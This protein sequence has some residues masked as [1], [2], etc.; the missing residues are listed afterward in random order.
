M[1][2]VREVMTR[3]KLVTVSPSA[4]VKEAAMRMYEAGVGSVLIVDEEMRLLGIFT[5]RDLVRIVATETPLD[6]PVS[7][8]MTTRLVTASPDESL[9]M[10]ASKMIEHGIRHI[11]VVDESGRLI[12]IV[13]IRDVLRHIVASG[14][15]P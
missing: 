15:W 1:S 6:T 7:R 11:P 13:S 9:A 12:G 2:S 3:D 14:S 10:V 4:T 5:E 8:V